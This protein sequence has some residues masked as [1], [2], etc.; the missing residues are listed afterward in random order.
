MRALEG[1][2]FLCGFVS[3]IDEGSLGS[4]DFSGVP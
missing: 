1:L 4:S 2:E 3:G